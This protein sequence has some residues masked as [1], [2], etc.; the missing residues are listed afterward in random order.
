M[1]LNRD[2]IPKI[3]K[4][5]RELGVIYLI[6][7]EILPCRDHDEQ[8]VKEYSI[9]AAEH[10]RLR[11][12]VYPEMF[13]GNRPMSRSRKVRGKMFNCGVGLTSFSIDPYG[14]MNFCLEIDYPRYNILSEGAANCWEKIKEEIDE[15]NRRKD[16]VC[17]DCDLFD[18]CGW[19]PGRSYIEGNGFNACSDFFKKRALE[20]KQMKE[21]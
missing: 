8:W 20:L 21:R 1:N 14:Q 11:R 3:S 6:D 16:F 18:Y 4:Y 10:E 9:S 13:T 19:C 15:L 7:G 5:C 17:R 12:I 2:D